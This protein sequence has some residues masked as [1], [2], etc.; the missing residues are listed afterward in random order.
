MTP[1]LLKCPYCNE[2]LEGYSVPAFTAPCCGKLVAARERVKPVDVMVFIPQLH[3]MKEHGL[4]GD[5]TKIPG[6]VRRDPFRRDS[7]WTMVYFDGDFYVRL[8]PKFME[9]EK[10][11]FSHG[12]AISSR[13]ST[14]AGAH[15]FADTLD[16]FF[17][18]MAKTMR[19]NPERMKQLRKK[20]KKLRKKRIG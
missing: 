16:K 14:E 20:C 13:F 17:D 3:Y 12:V 11:G 2:K 10:A 4:E 8:T 15:Q 5:I 18:A 1:D 19:A 9:L 6:T 7:L